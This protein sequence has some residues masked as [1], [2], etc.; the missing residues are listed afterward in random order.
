MQIE[1]E[2][3]DH[4]LA[5]DQARCLRDQNR[6]LTAATLPSKSTIPSFFYLGNGRF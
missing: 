6:V 1:L 5:A 2:R 4:G 3:E